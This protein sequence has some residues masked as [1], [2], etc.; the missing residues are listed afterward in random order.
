MDEQ[1]AV[2]HL[3]RA[4]SEWDAR[5]A[6][7]NE[8]QSGWWQS[9]AADRWAT[10]FAGMRRYLPDPSPTVRL[11]DAGCGSGQWSLA[12]A[13]EGYGVS[14]CDLSG[15]MANFARQNAEVAGVNAD[16]TAASLDAVPYPTATFDVVHCRCVLD[17]TPRPGH[18]LHEL[19]RVTKPG[20]VLLLIMMGARSPQKY[21]R[22]QRWLRGIDPAADNYSDLLNGIPPW[23]V[24]A[25]LPHL[26][27][28]LL[29]QQGSF[30][31]SG[32]GVVNEFG[33]NPPTDQPL[34]LQ[35]AVATF[36]Q[37]IAVAT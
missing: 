22:W 14:G 2:E 11:L 13:R 15:E 21:D 23:D 9:V 18:A 29:Q 17:F 26:G 16:F 6:T 35:Q 34:R 24:E 33:A 4:R 3:H 36:W 8:R 7:W 1:Q 10:T 19:R 28:Q 25:I 32:L 37:M 30:A 5:A 12:F 27:W 31:P 20:G